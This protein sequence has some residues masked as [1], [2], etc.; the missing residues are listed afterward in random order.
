MSKEGR[1]KADSIGGVL[2]RLLKC[3]LSTDEAWKRMFIV[4]LAYTIAVAN[5]S[6]IY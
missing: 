4:F 5:Y 2:I 3:S 6:S 1:M